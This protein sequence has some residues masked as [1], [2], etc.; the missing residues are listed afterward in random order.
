MRR[1]DKLKKRELFVDV[2]TYYKRHPDR[3][4]RK[5]KKRVRKKARERGYRGKHIGMWFVVMWLNYN[6][7]SIEAIKVH[8][9]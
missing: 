9:L 1:K 8:G 2:N 7:W 5:L 6:N 3:L 4:P